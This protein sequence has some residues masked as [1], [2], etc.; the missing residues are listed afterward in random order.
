[1]KPT[2]R[3]TTFKGKVTSDLQATDKAE[4]FLHRIEASYARHV[5]RVREPYLSM[6]I[7][8]AKSVYEKKLI[9]P[10]QAYLALKFHSRNG[11][12]STSQSAEIIRQTLGHSDTRQAIKHLQKC[13]A[14][15]WISQGHTFYY[16]RSF[17]RLQSEFSTTSRTAA[18]LRYSD[19]RNIREWTL[20]HFAASRYRHFDR[21][22]IKGRANQGRKATGKECSI[23]IISD[24][25]GMSYSAAHY[26]KQRAIK[27][28]YFTARNR[29]Q[30]TGIHPA[31]IDIAR[32][33]LDDPA[34]FVE[35]GSVFR[36]LPDVF[37][38]NL[39][40]PGKL[41]LIHF[42]RRPKYACN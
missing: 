36:R 1:M 41:R 35:S 37:R 5:D 32:S 17:E 15:N 34:L 9:K 38:F 3:E 21:V 31:Y 2:K 27:Q 11:K 42:T 26:L 14:M 13:L 8:L 30:R 6:P 39:D 18:V 33:C 23:G 16:I 4:K 12:V 20:A 40:A 7:Q 19:I 29:T 10:F 24:E 28:A 22:R 25:L